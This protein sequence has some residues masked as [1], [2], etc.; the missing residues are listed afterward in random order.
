MTANTPTSAAPDAAVTEFAV[1]LALTDDC[2]LHCAHC[3]R[4]TLDVG[5]LTLADVRAICDAV[6]VRSVN[7]GTGE[8]GLHPEYH[9]VLAFLRQRGVRHTLTTNGYSVAVLDDDE[10]RGFHSVEVSIDFPTAAEQDAFRAPGNWE[11]CLGVLGRCRRLGVAAGVTAVMMS[12]NYDR[13]VPIARLAAGHGA[14]FRVNVYQ[15]VKTDRFA[16]TYDQF[17]EGFRRLFAETEVLACTEPLVNALLGLGGIAG[18]G[19]GKGTLRVTAKRRVLPCVYWPARGAGLDE[20]VQRGAAV[21][22]SREWQRLRTVPGACQGCPFVATCQGGCA[23]RRLLSGRLDEP[24]EFCPIVRGDEVTLA[25][26]RAAG[27]D[28]PKAGSACTTIVAAR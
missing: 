20:L 25:W 13:L 4:D 28:L 5:H 23:S 1:G 17:W 9:D 15:P 19:C 18:P 26:A 22:A 3:Y 6:A 21:T 10:L 16:L 8:N 24:D 11:G 14:T 27:R 12:V 2:D 7:L